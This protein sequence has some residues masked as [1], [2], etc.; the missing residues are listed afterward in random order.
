MQ[1]RHRRANEVEGYDILL[2]GLFVLVGATEKAGIL[3]LGEELRATGGD[4]K[5]AA[6]AIWARRCCRPR[7][8][9]PLSPPRSR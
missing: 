6:L 8:Q 7:G 2:I 9:Y 1:P 5:T 4:A 3:D